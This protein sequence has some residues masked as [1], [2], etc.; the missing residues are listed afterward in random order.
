MTGHDRVLIFVR[1]CNDFFEVL[2]AKSSEIPHHHIM[3]DLMQLPC[4]G[5]GLLV[6]ASFADERVPS[7]QHRT[8]GI[9]RA[10][11]Q[12]LGWRLSSCL[13]YSLLEKVF[14]GWSLRCQLET[15]F[16]SESQAMFLGPIGQIDRNLQ[17]L[18]QWYRVIQ[19]SPEVSSCWRGALDLKVSGSG[20]CSQFQSK[21][22]QP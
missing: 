1:F 8:A 21:P 10:T 11:E 7:L 15:I 20:P 19:L 22:L 12:L 6:I 14:L 4:P 16:W 5:F 13:W 9:G 3:H 2:T 17:Q 18:Y